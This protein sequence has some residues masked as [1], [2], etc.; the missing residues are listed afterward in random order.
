VLA[1]PTLV[2]AVAA[3]EQ[4]AQTKMAVQVVQA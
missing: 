2:V 1:L 4:M 3:D